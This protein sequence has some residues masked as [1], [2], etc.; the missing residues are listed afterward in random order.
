MLNEFI[1]SPVVTQL[2]N[3]T[4]KTESS[5][6]KVK[7]SV[8]SFFNWLHDSEHIPTSREAIL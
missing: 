6:N 7:T 3:G 5:V 2:K 4:P 8:K 1:V